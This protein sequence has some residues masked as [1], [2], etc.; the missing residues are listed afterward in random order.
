MLLTTPMPSSFARMAPAGTPRASENVRTVQGSVDH[1]FALARRGR[2]GAGA[3]DVRGSPAGGRRRGRLFLFAGGSPRAGHPLPLELPLLAAA[4]G[5]GGFFLS[6]SSFTAAGAAAA[7]SFPPARQGRSGSGKMT[8]SVAPGRSRGD[9]RLAAASSLAFFSSCLRRCSE[10]GLLPARVAR[11][12][13]GG[14]LMSGFC[15]TGSLDFGLAGG[16]TDEGTGAS[17]MVGRR[18]FLL[19]RFDGLGL[20]GGFLLEGGF[21]RLGGQHRHLAGHGPARAQV[22]LAAEGCGAAVGGLPG[23]ALGPAAAAPVR[24]GPLRDPL[25]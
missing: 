4:Q 14:S 5:L 6:L 22:V 3:A 2:V 23:A 1:D 25:M 7:R 20:F 16:C 9:A 13:S 15:G 8:F 12:A 10:S 21:F 19:R 18:A 24:A 17:F 11:M